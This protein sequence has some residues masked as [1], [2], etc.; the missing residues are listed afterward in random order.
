MDI[1]G[2]TQGKKASALVVCNRETQGNMGNQKRYLWENDIQK[3][4]LA[5]GIAAY[6][7]SCK[8]ELGLWEI[9]WSLIL[10]I[11]SKTKAM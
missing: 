3:E 10:D 4:S 7:L 5:D 8:E 11:N 6:N 1:Q 2:Y 9:K